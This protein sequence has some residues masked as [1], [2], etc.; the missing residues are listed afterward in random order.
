M[1]DPLT[2]GSAVTALVKARQMHSPQ[3][4]L[5]ATMSAQFALDALGE[6]ARRVDSVPLMGGASGLGLGIALGRPDV[7]VIVM[8]GDASLLMEL[9][10]LATVAQNRPQRYL[11]VVVHNRVQFN[12]LV[13]LPALSSAPELD[14]AGM[15]LAAGYSQACTIQ[16]HAQWVQALPQL[17]S[18]EGPV[19]VD[20]RVRQDAPLIGA[21]PHGCQRNRVAFSPCSV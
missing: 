20:L 2:L 14:F 21:Q 11:H 8:D 10:S 5:V 19:M 18:H 12:G 1:N 6:T 7:P 17:L 16:S 9:G 13:N 15:A 3:A 4:V